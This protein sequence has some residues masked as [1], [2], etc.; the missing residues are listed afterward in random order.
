MSAGFL[1]V[2]SPVLLALGQTL[3]YWKYAVKARCDQPLQ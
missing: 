1:P 3:T 2:Q